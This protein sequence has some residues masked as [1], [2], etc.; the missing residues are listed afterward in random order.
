MPGNWLGVVTPGQLGHAALL[1]P[2]L[3]I[4]VVKSPL[5][6]GELWVFLS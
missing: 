5:E 2:V 6:C 3:P 1:S 4:K